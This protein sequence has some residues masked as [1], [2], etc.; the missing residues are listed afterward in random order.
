MSNIEAATGR[1][2]TRRSVR[3]RHILFS[4]SGAYAMRWMLFATSY[5]LANASAAG[6]AENSYRCVITERLTENGRLSEDFGPFELIIDQAGNAPKT[7]LLR[8][9]AG[10]GTWRARFVL[11]ADEAGTLWFDIDDTTP[12]SHARGVDAL[13]VNLENG[14]LSV[15]FEWTLPAPPGQPSRVIAQAA[16]LG[17]CCSVAR[18]G[19]SW[20]RG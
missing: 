7:A 6:A 17:Q 4:T 12:E 18:A 15:Y 19:E 9:A 2:R 20:C 11:Q 8:Q 10:D 16:L 14:A 1:R 13:S 3:R 5:L